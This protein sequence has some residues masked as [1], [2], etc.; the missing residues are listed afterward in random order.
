[1]RAISFATLKGGTG[2]TIIT[3]NVA[4]IL[5]QRSKRILCIDG[6]PQANLSSRM[7]LIHNEDTLVDVFEYENVDPSSVIRK[8]H[9]ENIDAICTNINMTKTEFKLVS[10]SGRELILE[11]FIEDNREFFEENYDYI[12]IDTNPSFS[13]INQNIF[14]AS[15]AIILVNDPSED[16][17]SGSRTFIQLWSQVL[18]R[19]RRENNIKGF[20]INQ[21]TKRRNVFEE[22]V[23]YCSKDEVIGE[24]LFKNFI[25]NTVKFAEANLEKQPINIY[26][27][28][29]EASL[30]LSDFVD[31]LLERVD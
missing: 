9:I 26:D 15:D 25:P 28:N 21:Y 6:D 14:L 5:A 27:K 4:G 31:E 16:S 23:D 29:S 22:F 7:G 13:V 12:L 18:K 20:L 8:T 11:N 19:L 17:L 2:K 1:M 3:F 24:L 10:I 30:I